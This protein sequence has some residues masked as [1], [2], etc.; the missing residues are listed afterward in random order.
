MLTTLSRAFRTAKRT[1]SWLRRTGRRGGVL[2]WMLLLLAAATTL[3]LRERRSL[4]QLSH[5]LRTA[6]IRWVTIAVTIE[7]AIVALTV[8]KTQGLLSALGHRAGWRPLASIFF[9]RQVVAAAVPLGAPASLALFVRAVAP[10]GVPRDDAVYVALLFSLL[11]S[12]SFILILVPVLVWLG[13]EREVSSL[14]IGGSLLLLALVAVMAI[15]LWWL[16]S[17][18]RIPRPVKG[19]VSDRIDAFISHVRAHDLSPRHLSA[20]FILAIIVDLAGGVLLCATLRAVG[21]DATLA[22]AFG[23]YAVGTVFLLVSP[24]F[25]GIGIVELSMAAALTGLGVPGGSA[26]AAALLYRFCELWLPFVV[27]LMLQSSGHHAVR[28]LPPHLPVLVT[29]LTGLASIL[30]VLAPTLPGRVNQIDRYWPLAL[31]DVSRTLTLAGGFFLLFLSLSLWRRKRFAWLAALLLLGVTVVTH[32]VKGHDQ[33]IAVIALVNIGIL[34]AYRRRFRVRSDVPTIAQGFARLGLSLLLALGYGMSGFWFLDRSAFGTTFSVG[35]SVDRTV[36]LFFGIGYAGL[37]PRT[38][39]AAWFLDSFT[40]VGVI[41]V[42]YA[43]FSLARPVVWRRRIVPAERERARQ[44]IEQHGNSSLDFFKHGDDKLFFFAARGDGVVC[45]GLSNATAIVLGDPI[46]TDRTAF[47]SLLAEFLTFCDANGWRA[48]FH[49]ASPH[50][51]D[52]YRAAGLSALKIGEDAIVDLE[53]FTLQGGSMKSLRSTDNRFVRDGFRATVTPPP[54]PDTLLARLREVSDEWLTLEGRRERA[55]TLGQWD[56]A[57]IRHCPVVT[58]EEPSGRVLAFVNLIPDGVPGEATLD[59]MRHRIAIPNGTMD[60]LFVQLFLFCQAQGYRAV[61]LGM[62]PFAAIGTGPGSRPLERG[63]QLLS[64][65]LNRFFSA[66]GLR[67]YKDKFH[68]IWEP[69]YLFYRSELSLP[70][71]ALA[72]VRLTEGREPSRRRRGFPP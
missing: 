42:T 59:L 1:G 61:S 22:V 31:S 34:L 46:A 70:A 57:Y 19:R 5:V 27:G 51:F 21:A 68:P 33:I 36:R 29:G 18:R 65:H 64:T 48:A 54:L 67:A 4:L 13:L 63:I 26:I 11:G 16:L 52:L 3:V 17:G 37:T 40:V 41:S 23:G 69:R 43:V 50:F 15:A 49:Q 6:D 53:R 24:V 12:A 8:L 55:F 72:I 20:P 62:V 14:L 71:V 10:Y 7:A 38:R 39:Y 2:L 35:E 28:R 47:Q 32:L 56:D 45:Y 25:Q 9:R 30:S 60:F 44:L 66:Q 58:V